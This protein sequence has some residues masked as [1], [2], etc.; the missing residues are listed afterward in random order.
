MTRIPTY[1][2]RLQ[3]FA[4]W[5]QQGYPILTYHKIGPRPRHVRLRGLYLSSRLFH[6]QMIEFA[7]ARFRTASLDEFP[8]RCSPPSASVVLTFDDGFEN[9]F[10]HALPTLA[11]LGFRSIQ[12]LVAD[13]LG[14]SNDWE[15][16]EKEQP[17]RLMDPGQIREWIA[18]GQEIGAHSCSHPWLTRL[19]LAKAREEIVRS[20]KKLEDVFG[21]AVRHFCYPYG[22]Y[23]PAVA[24]LV[25]E[26]G[27]ATA[28]TTRSGLNSLTTRALEL[29]RLTTR[30]RSWSL[31]PI[32]QWWI[33]WMAR[34]LAFSNYRELR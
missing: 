27:Y 28:C 2:T 12:F 31:K 3:P 30:Y 33:D 32:K 17:E 10:Q 6:K 5:F 20:K 4:S 22:D 29:F 34:G 26:A 13:R 9:V 16:A 21:Q 15:I 24:D 25:G 8:P 23:N 7:G 1:Y 11:E 18:A 19:P 14:G